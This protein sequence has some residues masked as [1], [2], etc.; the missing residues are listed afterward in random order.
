MFHN[1]ARSFF[2]IHYVGKSGMQFFKIGI[3]YYQCLVGLIWGFMKQRASSKGYGIYCVRKH[4][5]KPVESVNS[6]Y[7][8]CDELFGLSD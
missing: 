8:A 4:C 3:I 6:S 7:T 1:I 5:L 2:T